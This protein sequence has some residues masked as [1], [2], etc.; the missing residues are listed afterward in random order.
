[1]FFWLTLCLISLININNGVRPY[2]FIGVPMTWENA[3]RYCEGVFNTELA[4]IL[5]AF[6]NSIAT[7]DCMTGPCW[8]GLN[9]RTTEGTFE[10]IDGSPV[11]FTNFVPGQPNNSSANVD[12]FELRRNTG[13][14]NDV[15]CT[16]T[17]RFLCNAPS[18]VCFDNIAQDGLQF[19]EFRTYDGTNNNLANPNF[20]V[21]NGP[22]IRTTPN[23]FTDAE[24][25]PARP[26][27]RSGR[28]I[29]NIVTDSPDA[30]T[31]P[32]DVGLS[33]LAWVFGQF[34]DHELVEQ[35]AS[36]EDIPETRIDETEIC[37][38]IPINDPFFLD[39]AQ[40]CINIIDNAIFNATETVDRQINIVTS[41]IDGSA[42]YGSEPD[43]VLFLRNF[44]G[45]GTMNVSI[46]A[47]GDVNLPFNTVG[48]DNSG[49][50]SRE[51]LFVAGEVRVNENIALTAMHTLWVRNHNF[52]ASQIAAANPFLTGD[53]IFE[54]AR[55][56][57]QAQIQH[58]TY[59][60]WLPAFF[61]ESNFA[62]FINPDA[63]YDA[64]CD[65][66]IAAHFSFVAFRVGH[67]LI[68]DE[69][70]SKDSLCTQMAPNTNTSLLDA[71]TRPDI[72]ANG[73][74]VIDLLLNGLSCT[75]ARQV[76]P[77]IIFT[78]R[79]LLQFG[80]N[81]DT[82]PMDLMAINIQRARDDGIANW[83][84]L[85]QAFGLQA[86]TSFN[87]ITLNSILL[88]PDVRNRLQTAYNGII[89]DVDPII[90]AFSEAHINGGAFGELIAQQWSDQF[91][92]LVNC[93]RFWYTRYLDRGLLKYVESTTMKN[94]VQQ[95]ANPRIEFGTNHQFIFNAP[96]KGLNANIAFTTIRNIGPGSSLCLRAV[97][98]ANNNPVI[99]QTCTQEAADTWFYNT[100][101]KEVINAVTGK[102]LTV[103]MSDFSNRVE[104][105][106]VIINDCTGTANQKWIIDSNDSTPRIRNFIGM[107]L[108][109]DINLI[110]TN[111]AS[112]NVG[113]CILPVAVQQQWFYTGPRL[114]L[115]NGD[116]F[117]TSL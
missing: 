72:I 7:T 66:S 85:R 105:G 19:D 64:T 30:E 21:H 112:V 107:C 109:V 58:V 2:I 78:L 74:R 86:P 17:K 37:I 92:R 94:I 89:S 31:A 117:S 95:N 43:R 48:L 54:Y 93:D 87:D 116:L 9:D 53:E 60:E 63:P 4:T 100:K 88:D 5:D 65:A 15:R 26:T 51:D 44:D 81:G 70:P 27:A 45:S 84:T 90:G 25:S 102:C 56:V 33:N 29:S 50:A 13:Q 111:L 69:L 52:L 32:S 79:N 106:S 24:S 67:T 40:E 14:W 62:T 71:F 75:D 103:R 35:T 36:M 11:G 49:G 34:M 47:N 1:M 46:N 80:V 96:G 57:N 42:V 23:G 82:S 8:I 22:I 41:F 73:A 16:R 38:P 68:S 10:W 108:Q 77:F 98:D 76:D 83:V 115:T 20:G 18:T 110:F 59:T 91:Q 113:T 61:G 3:N 39:P 114:A 12:C 97:S 6:D 28:V 104:G 101:S 55:A 99:L